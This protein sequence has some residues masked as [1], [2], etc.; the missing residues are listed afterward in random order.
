M[1]K[2]FLYI[3]IGMCNLWGTLLLSQP[4][5]ELGTDRLV[6]GSA[7]LDAGNPGASFEWNTGESTQTIEVSNTG[8]YWVKVTNAG[9]EN[10]DT[11]Q[12]TVVETA[13]A[14]PAKDTLVCGNGRHRVEATT[15][16]DNVLWYDLPE[17]GELIG[18]ERFLDTFVEDSLTVYASTANFAPEY[19][20]GENFPEV[21]ASGSAGIRFD[22]KAPVTI[23]KVGVF[24]DGDAS[25]DLV[26]RKGA[27]LLF[28]RR[29]SVRLTGIGTRIDLP[30]FLDLPK[31]NN[32][33][34]L[35]A[36][37]EGPGELGLRR[38]NLNF[39]YEVEDLISLK[40]NQSGQM[41]NY[42]YFFQWEVSPLR[43][44]SER[45]PIRIRAN[46]PLSLPD[47]LYSCEGLTLEAGI[48][49]ES[50][51]WNTQNQTPSIAIDQGGWYVL[52]VSD[53]QGCTASDSTFVE[54]P[55]GDRP[56]LR[57]YTLWKHT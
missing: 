13:M 56:A 43:C 50:Y 31:G 36:N 52:E 18:T 32:Y 30:L 11:I 7:I 9:G 15:N 26:I 16:A 28:S 53:N 8:E 46:L 22:V 5:V 45:V 55:P 37:L 48:E 3:A 19:L 41:I 33:R 51:L 54:F 49:A 40:G 34:L 4:M 44:E 24:V 27:D 6:C 10:S 23:K 21:Y 57:R 39:P 2:Y 38:N 1:K 17:G 12:V 35:L 29:F 14:L 25:F 20:I 42:P 47:S